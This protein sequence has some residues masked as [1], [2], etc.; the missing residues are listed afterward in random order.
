[1]YIQTNLVVDPALMR[2]RSPT[3]TGTIVERIFDVLAELGHGVEEQIGQRVDEVEDD[4]AGEGVAVDERRD[5]VDDEVLDHDFHVVGSPTADEFGFG[6]FVGEADEGEDGAV[7]VV[8]DYV[9][10]VA[11]AEA[12][13]EDVYAVEESK[14]VLSRRVDVLYDVALAVGFE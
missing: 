7:V 3:G 11:E 10:E 4:L 9:E 5:L 6:V 14:D 12:E 2:A 8:A 13:V 1:M